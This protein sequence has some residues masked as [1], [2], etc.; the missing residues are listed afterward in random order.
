MVRVLAVRRAN[1]FLMACL[2][3]LA[4]CSSG[5]GSVFERL[6]PLMQNTVLGGLIPGGEEPVPELPVDVTRADLNAVPYAMIA[7]RIEDSPPAF[8][9]PVADNGGYLVYQD[10]ARRAV[11]MHG[12]LITATHGLGHDLDALAHER[13]D[14]VAVPTPLPEWPGSIL[15]SYRFA[16]QGTDGYQ[17]AVGCT[18][19][20]G[21][22]ETIEIVELTFE[23]VRIVETCSN[24]R[25]TFTNT[26]WVD[27]DSG[28]IW[29]SQQWV[30]PNLEPMMIDII[31]PYA[32]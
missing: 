5:G 1:A 21:V 14:P 17:I 10:T 6:A 25:R 2:G 19:E 18:F 32:G 12:G 29:R 16:V 28:F 20:R 24:P 3:A 23:V 7:L 13:E 9:V 30:G 26:Y 4:A 31:R 27:P 15:R 8:V 22:R 11:V